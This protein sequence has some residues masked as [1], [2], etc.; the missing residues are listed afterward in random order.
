[1]ILILLHFVLIRLPQLLKRS[2]LVY[3][4]SLAFSLVQIVTGVVWID[5]HIILCDGPEWSNVDNWTG[6]DWMIFYLDPDSVIQPYTYDQPE[7]K[8][9]NEISAYGPE[10]P[11]VPVDCLQCDQYRW[12]DTKCDCKDGRG[13]D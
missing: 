8:N 4:G 7:V 6:D 9:P 10:D 2:Y 3:F 13:D 5:F 1:M 11:V 12:S